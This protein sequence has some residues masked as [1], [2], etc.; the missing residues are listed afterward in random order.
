MSDAMPHY[1]HTPETLCSG[2]LDLEGICLLK[3]IFGLQ[4]IPDQELAD[5]HRALIQAVS[6]A[7]S[8]K[9]IQ[10]Q[11][12]FVSDLPMSREA[13]L[14]YGLKRNG[15]D[16]IL[17]HSGT[18]SFK[19]P[20]YFS[21]VFQY[22]SPL[23]A[24]CIAHTLSPAVFH[25]FSRWDF[26]TSSAFIVYRPGKVVFD[27]YDVMAGMV[28]LPALTDHQFAQYHLERFCL[29]NADGL[30]CRSLETQ[31]AKRHLGYVYRGRRIFFTDYCWDYFSVGRRET[32]KSEYLCIANVGNLY[33]DPDA[34]IGEAANYHL[35]VAIELSDGSICSTLYKANLTGKLAH[36]LGNILLKNTRIE[37][38]ELP[39]ET[40]IKELQERHHA[41]LICAPPG[42]AE[43]SQEIY[44]QKKRVYSIGNK[45]FDYIDAGLVII[46]DQ[47]NKFLCWLVKRYHVLVD[48]GFFIK[49]HAKYAGV[50]RDYVQS[51]Q[52]E[53]AKTSMK[54]AV[55]GQ[56]PRLIRFYEQL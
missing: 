44:T 17:L 15:W 36:Y 19:A 53:L 40:L 38:K 12:V 48:F 33:V 55:A 50:I 16:T 9:R 28:K 7:A 8:R 45:A 26:S 41:G 2:P 23:E 21:Q 14:A 52:E 47:E 37:F 6:A 10:K 56:A 11:A 29:E 42:I 51:Y 31:Y 32:K 34:G 25:L 22:N 5:M 18:A 27:D 1:R 30:C 46:M 4:P 24:L 3:Q 49:N 54:L 35:Q 20:E 43:T 39:Y 13:K